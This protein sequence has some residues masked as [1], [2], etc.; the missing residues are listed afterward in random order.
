MYSYQKP[1]KSFP[2]LGLALL[3]SG[4]IGLTGCGGGGGSGSGGDV[5]GLSYS[6]AT[7][8]ATISSTSAKPLAETSAEA[9]I[10]AVTDSEGGKVSPIGVVVTD[11]NLSGMRARVVEVAKQLLKNRRV[12]EFPAGATITFNDLQGDG[13][14]GGT[15]TVP[16]NYKTAS[17]GTMTFNNACMT[18]PGYGTLIFH[19]SI[20][21][22]GT[23]DSDGYY[24]GAA[25]VTYKNV[26]VDYDLGSYGSGTYGPMN[27]TESCSWEDGGDYYNETC[28]TTEYYTG[29]GG[30]VYQI[31]DPDVYGSNDS[32]W[33][34]SATVYHPTY[35]YVDVTA[36]GLTF[37][38]SNGHPDSGHIGATGS[39]GTSISVDFTDCDTYSGSYNDGSG[40]V[41]FSGW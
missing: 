18:L 15:I 11:A 33:N 30:Q 12:M 14:C 6:G 32:G 5:A 37:N 22:S 31:Q 24:A 39:G 26:T 36:T 41:S 17:S 38:C 4:A 1:N 21:V 23:G 2:N 28:S 13:S 19:G 9:S 3:V 40:A 16:D 25:I 35:G 7:A 29:S 34:V 10:Q 20:Q 27:F 8:E